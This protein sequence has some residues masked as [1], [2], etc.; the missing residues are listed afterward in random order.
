MN[1]A[2][3]RPLRDLGHP[4]RAEGRLPLV[5][6]SR[7]LPAVDDGLRPLQP[8]LTMALLA[9]AAQRA[10]RRWRGDE[11]HRHRQHLHEGTPAILGHADTMR[12]LLGDKGNDADRLRNP[13]A[14]R[15]AT[16]VLPA[17]GTTS[18]PVVTTNSTTSSRTA[19]SPCRTVRTPSLFEPF[20]VNCGGSIC[21]DCVPER[22]FI[23]SP[24]VAREWHLINYI[25]KARPFAD[26]LLA[27]SRRELGVVAR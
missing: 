27:P 22:A 25:M 12:Y 6:L 15:G 7:G 16:P 1:Q 18:A 17:A 13:H 11:E 24:S 26:Q 3:R 14:M 9:E 5:R 19:F 21:N 23:L 4:A 20:S 8:L 2:G 10:S